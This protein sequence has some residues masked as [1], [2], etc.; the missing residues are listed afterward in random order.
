MIHIYALQ[1]IDL[2]FN[3]NNLTALDRKTLLRVAMGGGTSAQTGV[4]DDELRSES[5]SLAVEVGSSIIGNAAEEKGGVG[6]D[7]LSPRGL[8]GVKLREM[9]ETLD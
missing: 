9:N 1:W 2:C 3:R 6:D 7:V 5:E 4:D 8:R